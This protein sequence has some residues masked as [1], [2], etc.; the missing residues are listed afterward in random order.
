MD[1]ATRLVKKVAGPAAEEVGLS[2]QNSV[3]GME[4]EK[5]I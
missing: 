3:K 1:P 5:T 4:A 2:L